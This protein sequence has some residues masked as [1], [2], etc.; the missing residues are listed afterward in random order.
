MKNKFLN[1]PLIDQLAAE[2]MDLLDKELHTGPNRLNG[3]IKSTPPVKAPTKEPVKA[4]S[5]VKEPIKQVDEK[6]PYILA[7]Q[8]I[9]AKNK[10]YGEQVPVME[11][12]KDTE[13]RIYQDFIKEVVALGNTL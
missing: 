9:L 10:W 5:K 4:P 3:A 6:N 7:R 11:K 1:L 12:N 2:G 8:Q 13:N